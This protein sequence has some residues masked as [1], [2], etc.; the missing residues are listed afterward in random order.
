MNSVANEE[1]V[2]E[3]AEYL[4][5]EIPSRAQNSQRFTE[6]TRAAYEALKTFSAKRNWTIHPED[7]I[8]TGEYL[9]DFTLHE[10]GYGCRVACESQWMH[11]R[12]EHQNTLDWAFD[13]LRGVKADV[14]LF[15]FEAS[16]EQWKRTV[17]AHLLDYAQLS[18]DEA[19]L[20]LHWHGLENRFAKSWWKP[21]A[22]GCQTEA[23]K[24]QT[25]S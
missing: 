17:E 2:R 13:K 25:F 6:W 16:E 5:V 8:F 14:K 21:T 23:V 1:F 11:W 20:A 19:F 22:N 7:R 4:A 18:T 15:I 12:G 10:P 24:F 9:C 3:L